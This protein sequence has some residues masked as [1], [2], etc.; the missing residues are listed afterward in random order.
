MPVVIGEIVRISLAQVFRST[1]GT[2]EWIATAPDVYPGHPE[3]VHGI[4]G[5]DGHGGGD[6]EGRRCERIHILGIVNQFLGSL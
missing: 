3:G 1:S 6:Y 4:L 2:L 5:Q